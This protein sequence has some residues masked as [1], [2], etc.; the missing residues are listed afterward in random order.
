MLP[1]WTVV[2]FIC[3]APVYSDCSKA[4]P[5]PV[6]LKITQEGIR[7]TGY[8]LI[9]IDKRPTWS[10]EIRNAYMDDTKQG[11]AKAQR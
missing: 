10:A 1:S 3:N 7:L 9:L 11:E 2:D 5:R 6:K 4:W 8:N